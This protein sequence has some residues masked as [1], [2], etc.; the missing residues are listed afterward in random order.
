MDTNKR[1][2][3]AMLNKSF[4]EAKE[5]VFKSLY[6]KSSLALD[7]ARY[8]VANA[9]FNEAELDEMAQTAERK[10]ETDREE[11]KLTGTLAK[12]SKAWREHPEKGSSGERDAEH[13]FDKARDARWKSQEKADM[14]KTSKKMYGKGGKV[15]KK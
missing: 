14:E 5:L 11:K 10:K 13:E 6:A 8:T 9:I 1:I 7:E 12:R 15:V 4:A 2:A 3:R